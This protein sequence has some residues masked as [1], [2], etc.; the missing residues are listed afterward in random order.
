MNPHLPLISVIVIVKNEANYIE[1]TIK[2]ILAQDYP[3]L[4]IIVQD[5]CST[6]GTLNIIKD[7]PVKIVSEPDTGQ[8]NAA[9]KAANY[10]KGDFLLFIGGD[11]LLE[12][13]A[14]TLLAEALQSHPQAGFV[15]G[16]IKII[17]QNGTQYSILRGKPF[18]FDELFLF[19]FIPSQSVMVRRSAF[20]G[21]GGYD[22]RLIIADWD[23]RI[24]MGAAN[25]PIYVPKIVASYRI[26]ENSITL[27]NV[28]KI[29]QEIV[30][31]AENSVLQEAIRPAF[32]R[33][34]KRAL[35]GSYI[36]S[37]MSFM[38]GHQMDQSL[39]FYL[40]ALKSYPLIF[41]KKQSLVALTALALRPNRFNQ[42]IERKRQPPSS[43]IVVVLGQISDLVKTLRRIS[44]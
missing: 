11:D 20:L 38:R 33:N 41:F 3:N 14:I 29:A 5:A 36:L 19:N 39:K 31:V 44:G 10:S 27:R 25:K 6:D 13:G 2:S 42:F 43:K 18:D 24:R 32:H 26:H 9:N 12:P 4:E 37:S 8:A 1:E 34:P 23:L 28:G 16:D 7:F 30:F 40:K 35:A 17:D 15:Y 21:V 22:E